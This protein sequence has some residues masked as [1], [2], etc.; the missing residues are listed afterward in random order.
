MKKILFISVI[1]LTL[2]TFGQIKSEKVNGLKIV[3]QETV[4]ENDTIISV[5]YINKIESDRKPAYFINGKLTNESVLKTLNPNE[6]E[7]VNVEK[8]NFEI[9]NVN[10]K[11]K[12]YIV[13]KS[14]YKPKLISLNNLKMKYTS[15][16]ENST[17]FKIDNEIINADYENYVVDENYI[18]K[19]NVEKFENSQ[20]KL[21]FNIVNLITKT[22][23]NIKK[24]KEIIIRGKDKFAINK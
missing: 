8:G 16:K 14:T 13:T 17:I 2:N 12:L 5:N 10:Y 15:I 23:E 20:E 22:E 4:S 18:L 21:K 1:L 7:N 24:S 19:I 3:K 9:E 6:I 11:G